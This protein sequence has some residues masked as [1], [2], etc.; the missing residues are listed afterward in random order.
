MFEETEMFITL[1]YTYQNVPHKD[2]QT[3]FRNIFR[4]NSQSEIDN[5]KSLKIKIDQE[6]QISI[7]LQVT[8]NITNNSLSWQ[9]LFLL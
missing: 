9:F 2:V 6:A 5:K 7:W 1:I 8:E 3:S 4:I